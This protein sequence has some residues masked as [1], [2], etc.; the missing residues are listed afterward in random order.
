MFCLA[1]REKATYKQEIQFPKR[2]LFSL[3]KNITIQSGFLFIEVMIIFKILTFFFCIGCSVSPLYDKSSMTTNDEGSSIL[4]DIIAER[5]GQILRRCLMDSF[6]DLNF[7]KQKC[8]LTI[9]LNSIEK[10]FAFAS[11]GNAKRLRLFYNADVTFKDKMRKTLFHRFISVSR[12]SNISSAQG[13]VVLSLYSRGSLPLL[14]ELSDR[15][16]ENIKV[17]LSNEN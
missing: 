14:K 6:R 10:P 17:F 7:H 5:D 4:V 2:R 3:K 13:E 11:D 1:C 12:S 15:I 9:L 16:V 8:C